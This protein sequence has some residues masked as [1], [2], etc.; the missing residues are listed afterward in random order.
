VEKG[1]LDKAL[2]LLRESAAALPNLPEVQYHYGA[3]LARKGETND[4]RRILQQVVDSK[5]S[6]DVITGATRELAKLDR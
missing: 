6:A 2:P 1:D 5:A 3:A 4:A